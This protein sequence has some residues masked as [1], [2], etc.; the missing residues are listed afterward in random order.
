MQAAQITRV[1]AW[2]CR[3]PLPRPLKFRSFRAIERFYCAVRVQ[4]SGG[5]DGIC[6]GHTR[7]APL[8]VAILDVLAPALIGRDAT[9]PCERL[10]D[11]HRAVVAME[12]DGLLGRAISLLEICLWDIAGKVAGQPVWQLLG[13]KPRTVPV[14]LVEGNEIEGEPAGTLVA[15]M[16]ARAAEGFRMLKLE[17]SHYDPPARLAEDVMAIHAAV[18]QTTGG[19]VEIVTDFAWSWTSPEIVE[20][21]LDV[22]GPLRVGWVEDP[23]PC[24]QDDRIAALHRRLPC[25]LAIGD[26]TTRPADLL[27]LAEAGA[28]DVMRLDPTT[29]GGLGPA[30]ELGRRGAELGLR[31]SPH[32]NPEVARHLVLALPSCD[33]V[34]MF[35]ADRPFDM[36]HRL[37]E[38]AAWTSVRD[39]LLPAPTAPGLGLGLNDAAV[40]A[41][42]Y[43]SGAVDAAG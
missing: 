8:D 13:G 25:P 12:R 20:T 2:A 30:L 7:G 11:L 35:P 6:I 42:A 41:A 9:E 17:G 18:A 34:E 21:M 22:L 29:L 33:H 26:E 38:G 24:D 27:R 19:A 14:S 4:T 37:L 31:L 36:T 43:R 15:R 32:V 40:A 5:L 23:V 10:V 28:I 16:T 39:G 3:V 1:E